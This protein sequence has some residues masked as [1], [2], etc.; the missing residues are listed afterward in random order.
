M[1][2]VRRT[3]AALTVLTA[4]GSAVAAKAPAGPYAAPAPVPA[5]S[6]ATLDARFAS[7]ARDIGRAHAT[8]VR[9]GDRDRARALSAF[10]A[11]G[12]RF[13]AFD[14]RGDGRAV[15][16]I[17]DLRRAARI[18]VVVPGAD[19]ALATFDSV[20]FAGGGARAL[21]RRMAAEAPSARVAVIAWLGYRSPSTLG[22]HVLT[23]DRAESGARRLDRFLTGVARVNPDARLALLCH[24]YGSVVCGEAAPGLAGVP[25]D[26]IALF[27]SPGTTA[28]DV[29]GLRTSATVWAGRSTGDWTRFV[30]HVRFAGIGFG[31]D[32]VSPG[33]GAVRFDA[34]SGPH[35][36]YLTPGSPALRNLALIALG[37]DSEV[38]HA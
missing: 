16:V 1:R 33:F 13:L 30:P 34:G 6:A 2:W 23:D 9:T 11:P 37:R 10:R 35:S 15:E 24:S 36:A 26:D 12:R 7:A 21:Y 28:R 5:L 4:A 8:A 20:K 3:A 19:N 17:G 18:A 31:P 32:P 29:S 38:T 22:P 14:P 25:V 27:G